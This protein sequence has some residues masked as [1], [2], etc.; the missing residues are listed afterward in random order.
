M[1]IELQSRPLEIETDLETEQQSPRIAARQTL[2]TEQTWESISLV[3]NGI[4]EAAESAAPTMAVG[5]ELT[6]F[7]LD[8]LP[9]TFKEKNNNLAAHAKNLIEELK[10]RFAPNSRIQ[11]KKRLGIYK[12]EWKRKAGGKYCFLITL[13]QGCLKVSPP[14]TDNWEEL[15]TYIQ[16]LFEIAYDCGLSADKFD[17]NGIPCGTGEGS[18]IIIGGNENEPSPFLERPDLVLSLVSYLQ[19]HPSL[20]YLFSGQTAGPMGPAPRADEVRNDVL[21]ELEIASRFIPLPDRG[22]MA[23]E[24]I[25][26]IFRHML[27]DRTGNPSGGE[28]AIDNLYP[29]ENKE[30]QLGQVALRSFEMVPDP[31]LLLLQV[32]IVKAIMARMGTDPYR[33]KPVNWKNALQNEFM[34]PYFLEQD[35]KDVLLDLQDYGYNFQFH[36]FAAQFARR[37]PQLGTV[38]LDDVEL[39]LSVAIEPLNTLYDPQIDPSILPP[40]LKRLQLKTTHM[41]PDRHIVTCNGFQVPLTEADENRVQV[42]AIRLYQN[43]P[44]LPSKAVM[45]RT[46]NKLTFELVDKENKSSLGGFLFI[47]PTPEEY[48]N[49]EMTCDPIEARHRR[50]ASFDPFI[51]YGGEVFIHPSPKSPGNPHMLDMRTL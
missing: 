23:P 24:I 47:I 36:W 10:A 38:T 12:L 50:N 14:H 26:Q 39:D 5:S 31:R 45:K 3:A 21:Y 49:I 6:F 22:N 43:L 20:S 32:L 44:E 33:E 41:D 48:K 16:G 25:D 51:P 8:D 11:I 40:Q 28:I 9:L 7:S 4:M 13:G 15:N 1:D 37:F 46:P 34:L 42:A 35:F 30:M 17:A 18:R 29:V 2:I 27:T 19:N